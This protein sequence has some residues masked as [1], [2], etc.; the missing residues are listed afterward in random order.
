MN[1]KTAWFFGDSFT[2]GHGLRDDDEYMKLHPNRKNKLW[3]EM[4]CDTFNWNCNNL[5]KQGGSSQYILMTIIENLH[6]FKENDIVFISDTLPVRTDTITILKNK[7][8]MIAPFTNEMLKVSNNEDDIANT[9]AILYN[10]VLNYKRQHLVDYLHSFIIDYEDIWELYW[11]DKFRNIQKHLANLNIEC[12]L[13]SHK[14]WAGKQDEYNYSTIS[15]E[16]N[17][18]VDDGHWGWEGQRQMY[19]YML[20]RV[21]NKLY[22]NSN[23]FYKVNG[24]WTEHPNVL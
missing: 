16:T 12:Y 23:E 8:P 15:D 2:Y 21:N 5:G 6:K 18:I 24:I 22:F 13:W 19:E 4:L 17:R 14:I 20:S 7:P 9:V 1:T 10:N 3:S 11:I